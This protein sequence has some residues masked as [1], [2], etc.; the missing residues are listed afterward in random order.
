VCGMARCAAWP[1][2]LAGTVGS[3][4]PVEVGVAMEANAVLQR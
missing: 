2:S 4:V 3:S 1:G